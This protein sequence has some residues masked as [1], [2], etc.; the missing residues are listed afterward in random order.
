MSKKKNT[1]KSFTVKELLD[2]LYYC[3]EYN[4]VNFTCRLMIVGALS[5]DD[6]IKQNYG[7]FADQ[8]V[9]KWGFS[10]GDIDISLY[11]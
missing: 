2:R 11:A 5:R 3:T 9:I 10:D 8:L 6:V 7:Q 1:V 4:K